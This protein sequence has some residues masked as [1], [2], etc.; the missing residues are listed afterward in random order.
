[1]KK[2][3]RNLAVIVLMALLVY[4]IILSIFEF[5]SDH[6]HLIVCN[7]LLTFGLLI[8]SLYN[9]HIS[10]ETARLQTSIDFL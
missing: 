5:K 7:V 6:N 1:M 10:K 8:A 4:I 3:Y 9:F 2:F